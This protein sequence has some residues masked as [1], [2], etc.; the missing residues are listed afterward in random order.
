MDLVCLVVA[1]YGQVREL[2]RH[3]KAA[4]V[5]EGS[6]QRPDKQYSLTQAETV[7]ESAA[8][9]V[10]TVVDGKRLLRCSRSGGDR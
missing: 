3:E 2:A 8:A 7:S 1:C 5:S 10:D 9:M 4:V 6:K